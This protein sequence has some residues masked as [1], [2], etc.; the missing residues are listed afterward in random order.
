[1]FQATRNRHGRFGAALTIFELIY[2]S[3][4]RS[5]RKTH[6]NAFAAIGINLLQSVIF[7]GTFYIMFDMLG[8][9][10]AALRGDFLLYIMSG[11]FLFMV[12]TKSLAAVVASEGPASPM[13]QH[14]PL[15]TVITIASAALG[16][17]YIQVLCLMIILFVYHVAFT[18]VHIEEPA[19]AF[20]MLLLA[21]FTGSA[22]GVM[23]LA[24]KPWLPQ[25]VS[26]FTTIYQRANMIAS[27]KM[28]VA[29]AL[30]AYM[31]ALFDWNPL[32]HLID[33][34]RGYIFINYSPRITDWTYAAWVGVVLLMIG[35]MGEF[36]TRRHASL[37][38][39]A[40]R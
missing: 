14:A 37:S 33:E 10:G 25:F 13:M 23:L 15:N 40:R 30:P 28:F 22:L 18:P 3:I 36:Y 26:I 39:S 31:L 8:M 20:G 4:V 29:N 27:G 38:W 34:A 35:L 24:L 17:L 12:H 1:M 16:S 32:F 2:H 19:A 11:V 7:V 6:N 5:V 21:W 9:R